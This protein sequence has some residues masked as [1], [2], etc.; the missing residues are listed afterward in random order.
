MDS[1]GI[2]GKKLSPKIDFGRVTMRFICKT[3]Q[4]GQVKKY[5]LTKKDHF[6]KKKVSV[7]IKKSSD[8]N[9][10]VFVLNLLDF[11]S[12][13]NSFCSYEKIFFS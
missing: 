3:G 6:H 9:K 8:H 13:Q 5:F 2:L 12:Y 1:W 11:F 4:L 10:K 7:L